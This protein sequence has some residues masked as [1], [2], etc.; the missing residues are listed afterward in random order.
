[1]GKGDEELYNNIFRSIAKP[2]EDQAAN[3]FF[4]LIGENQPPNSL[5]NLAELGRKL[6]LPPISPHPVSAPLVNP[7][8]RNIFADAA[9]I[10]GGPI[11][12]PPIPPAK[13]IPLPVATP[14]HSVQW[15]QNAVASLLKE[16]PSV[17]DGRV[18]PDIEDLAIMEGRRVRAAFVYTDLHSFTKL[19]A[20]QP[21]NKS[22]V[23][24]QAFV[25]IA[26]QITKRYGGEVMEVAGDRV[27][28]VFH[29]PPGDRSNAPVEDAITFALWLQTLFDKAIGPAFEGGGLGKLTLGIGIDYGPAVIGCVGIRNH[30]KLVFFGDPANF[31]AKLQDMAGPGETILS[32]IAHYNRPAY[33]NDPRGWKPSYVQLPNSE[34]IVIRMTQKFGADKPP[35]ARST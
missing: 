23:F 24:L 19:V 4:G 29:R 11:V 9:S 17:K 3:N 12:P 30:K 18:L 8:L 21:E 33:L 15:A 6:S 22:F 16:K 20:T 2:P 14:D 5:R 27:L 13:R 26:N 34:T 1:M 28:S 31:A 10:L 32:A 35:S 25:E 7:L